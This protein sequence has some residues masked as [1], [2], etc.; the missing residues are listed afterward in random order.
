MSL[1]LTVTGLWIPGAGSHHLG[2]LTLRVGIPLFGLLPSYL[3]KA[4]N[5][6]FQVGLT[7]ID[8]IAA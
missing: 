3:F 1:L 7:V 5:I 8:V 4:I 2:V 6:A